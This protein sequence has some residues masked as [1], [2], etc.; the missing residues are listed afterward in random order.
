MTIKAD[1]D[2]FAETLINECL[3]TCENPLPFHERLDA[4]KAVAAYYAILAKTKGDAPP[5]DEGDTFAAFRKTLQQ[6]EA[7][8]GREPDAGK[9]HPGRRRRPDHPVIR[10]FGN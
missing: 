2:R 5:A 10:P 8:D 6:P 4:F 1:I 9:I 7:Q 3:K